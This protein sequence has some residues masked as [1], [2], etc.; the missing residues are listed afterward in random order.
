MAILFVTHEAFLDHDAGPHHPESPARLVAV[1]DGVAAAGVADGVIT[2][3]PRA[4]TIDELTLVHTP[5]Y[6]ESLARWCAAGG[7][8]LDPDTRA[9]T[10]SWAAALHAAGAGL[11]A[12]ERLRSG[13]ADA[14]FCAVRPPGHHA[15]AGRPMGFCLFNNVAVCAAALAEQGERVLIVDWDAHHGNGTQA[16]FWEDGRVG[17]VSLHQF[18]LWPFSGCLEES[19]AGA[20]VGLTA[21]VPLP[22]GATG[23]HYLRAVDEVVAPLAARLR[24]TWLLISAGFDAHCF[25]PLTDLG[26]SAGDF[27]LLA[28]RLVELVPR[29]RVVAFL[30]GGYD[31]GALALSAGACV[32]ALVGESWMPERPSFGGDGAEAVTAAAEQLAH[33]A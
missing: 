7:G 31:L 33:F 22:A 5:E 9:S 18:P 10:G 1:R 29:G 15:L 20:G 25:D 12:V 6:V 21:N 23:E 14:A 28:T 17:F 26:L 4:A 13:D 11:A 8:K 32:A 19:G 3:T 27:G 30:E 16:T 2:V 24:P